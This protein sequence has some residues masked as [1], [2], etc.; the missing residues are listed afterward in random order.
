MMTN[1]CIG[2][3]VGVIVW[4]LISFPVAIAIGRRLREVSK[5]YP[6]VRE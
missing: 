3:A 1:I 6:E 2:I 4:L 5:Y